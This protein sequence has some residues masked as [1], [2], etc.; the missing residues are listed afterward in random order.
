MA[1]GQLRVYLGLAP[2]VGKTYKMLDEGWRR[3]ER[4]ADVVAGYVETHRRPLTES[5]LR[6]IEVVPRRHYEYRG[7][8]L[9]EMDLDGVLSRQP[10]VA[11]VDELAHTNAPGSRHE[12]RWQD[13]EELLEAGIDV[14]T[15][16]N[17]QHL[18]SVNDV[19]EK[20]TGIVQRET[21]PDFVVR[22]A[23][24][25]ELVDI[26]PEALRRR[27]AH[28]NIYPAEKID[29][30]LSNFFRSGN[31][32]ALR[33]LS[34]LWL[35][36]RVEDSLQSYLAVHG[37]T[38][39]W[40]TRER[41]IVAVAG[42]A[43]DEVLLRRAA[44]MASRNH[45]EIVAV[46]VIDAGEMRRRDSDTTTA[47]ELIQEF[48]GTFHE[49]IDEDVA[50]ALVAFARAERGT[51]I[52]VGSSRR[53]R[54][55]RIP[56]G[57]IEK[58]LRE[59]RDLDVHIIAITSERRAH[60][61]RRRPRASFSW[62]TTLRFGALGVV[63]LTALTWVL[64]Q[65]RAGASLSTVF[66]VYLIVV[67]ALAARGGVVVGIVA[68]LGASGLENYYFVAPLHTL[69]VARPDDAVAIVA[70]LAFALTAGLLMNRLRR[71]TEDARRA[72]AEAELLSEAVATVTTSREDLMPLLDTLR[73]VF[74]VA[75][76][77]L[78][79]VDD[80]GRRLPELVSGDPAGTSGD[81]IEF[82]VS[83]RWA[84]RLSSLELDN[85]D[86]QLIRAF[87]ARLAAALHSQELMIEAEAMRSRVE[88]DALRIGLLRS[89][90]HDLKAPLVTIENS[91]V[92]LRA[93]SDDDVR[94]KPLIVVAREVD[95]LT[96]LVT[97][98]LD[99]SRLEAKMI[100]PRRWRTSLRDVVANARGLVDTK[101]RRVETDLAPDLP[102]AVTDPDLL[103][104]VVINLLANACAFSPLDQVVRVSAGCTPGEIELLV[105]DRGPDTR[106]PR[107]RLPNL[108]DPS[109]GADEDLSLLVAMGFVKVLGGELRFEDTPGGGV[110]AV[111]SLVRESPGDQVN[112][113]SD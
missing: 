103:E 107:R 45:A 10:Q 68:A 52:I 3:R 97:N 90:A 2:G 100:A 21:V 77:T 61:A 6:D 46:H 69:A 79:R 102:T 104:R 89:V 33:E 94:A 18:E 105:I 51:Q 60:T 25:I 26:T 93:A 9:E 85:Q 31:L 84:L 111:V 92:A 109:E 42:N 57:V 43:A 88:T 39:T 98:L 40:E 35:A 58:V 96:R 65:V 22:R 29:A 64:S 110:T 106:D 44:R 27:M 8:T 82:S 20:I 101:G 24:Q 41:L 14:I 70:F 83:E 5:Q 72:R 74:A 28:G 34:L 108:A 91:L 32:T 113:P 54:T 99:S 17:I 63:A 23:E 86:R 112:A 56:G 48:E 59:A 62:P 80:E 67:L 78:E 66:L 30:S 4:G 13:V 47:R 81:T 73:A 71:A 53:R 76:V 87:C 50:N 11:L 36:D 7:A 95:N 38:G 1:R 49:V 19:V 15:T 16:V 55:W 75:M 12:K 37:I